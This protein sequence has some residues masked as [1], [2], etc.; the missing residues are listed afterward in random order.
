MTIDQRQY[1]RKVIVDTREFKSPLPSLLYHHGF[2]VIP[3]F[4]KT[5]DYILSD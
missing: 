3:M 5:A 2:E 4:L 1:R